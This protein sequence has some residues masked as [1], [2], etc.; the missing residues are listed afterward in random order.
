MQHDLFPETRRD[1]A[2]ARVRKNSGEWFDWALAAIAD[3]PPNW[4]GIGEDIRNHITAFNGPPHDPHAWGSLVSIAV[5]RKLL[6]PTGRYRKMTSPTSNAR[7][8]EVYTR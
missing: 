6:K 8:S 1:E 4:S 3:L 5:R 7:K 2:L